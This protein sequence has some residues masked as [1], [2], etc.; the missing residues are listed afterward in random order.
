MAAQELVE[1]AWST[2]STDLIMNHLGK[3]LETV[4]LNELWGGQNK[5]PVLPCL[6]HSFHGLSW[7]KLISAT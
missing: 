1:G 3:W 4:E 7:L 6:F 2:Q 5:F